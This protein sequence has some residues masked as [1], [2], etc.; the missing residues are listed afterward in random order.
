MTAGLKNRATMPS[1]RV[2]GRRSEEERG[3]TCNLGDLA[4]ITR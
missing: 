1:D 4:R 3:I 2:L